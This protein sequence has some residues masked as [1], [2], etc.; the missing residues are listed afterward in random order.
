M[1]RCVF[2]KKYAKMWTVILI[3]NNGFTSNSKSGRTRIPQ[4]GNYDSRRRRKRDGQLTLGV[5]T[6]FNMNLLTRIHATVTEKVSTTTCPPWSQSM[7]CVHHRKRSRLIASGIHAPGR[8]ANMA[9][10]FWRGNNEKRSLIL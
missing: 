1:Q 7:C 6:S 2:H 10:K 4:C 5:F 9:G 8:W 3:M